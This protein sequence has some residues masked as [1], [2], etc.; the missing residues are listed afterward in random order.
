[1]TT[2]IKPSPIPRK[3]NPGMIT[4][5]SMAIRRGNY[6]STACQLC[7]IDWHTLD[8]WLTIAQGERAAGIDETD[9][10][11]LQL[12]TAIKNAEG[13]NE[14]ELVQVVRDAA[15]VKREWLPAITM[16]ERRHRERWGRP[17]PVQVQVNNDNRQVKISRVEIMLP[18]APQLDSVN[19]TF[20]V[21]DA[22]HDA[23]S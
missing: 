12:D 21:L 17:A 16:L 20:K 3:L 9:S 22:G 15:T 6:P 8:S 2:D 7:G 18:D 1:M 13:V 19:T 4:A 14:S 10:L 5:L 23:E 11:Y